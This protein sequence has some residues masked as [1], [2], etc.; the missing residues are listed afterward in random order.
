[1]LRFD[2]SNR[3]LG[4]T[5]YLRLTWSR[6]VKIC[7]LHALA[8]TCCLWLPTC[9]TKLGCRAYVSQGQQAHAVSTAVCTTTT[10]RCSPRREMSCGQ[11]GH[12]CAA[13]LLLQC[14][15]PLRESE[16]QLEQVLIGCRG[17]CCRKVLLSEGRVHR[18]ANTLECAYHGEQAA[19]STV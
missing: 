7:L 12:C 9:L 6:L 14:V 2:L 13:G 18:E 4:R 10:R 11:T 1:M 3:L 15:G 8:G 19:A 5:C 17:C 16:P